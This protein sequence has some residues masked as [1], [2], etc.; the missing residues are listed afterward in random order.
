[1]LISNFPSSGS[2]KDLPFDQNIIF[3]GSASYKDDGDGNWRVKFLT[4]GILTVAKDV[5]IDIFAVGGGGNGGDFATTIKIGSSSVYH[6]GG[7]GGGGYTTTVKNIT[8]KKGKEYTVTVGA[9]CSASG[10]AAPDGVILCEAAGGQ[11]ASNANG[12]SGGSG[13]GTGVVHTT[14]ASAPGSDGSSGVDLKVTTGGSSAT[15]TGGTGQQTTTREFGEPDGDLY[16][17]GGGGGGS[18]YN[19]ALYSGMVG[20]A[21]GG[22][23]GA[24]SSRSTEKLPSLPGG[25]NTGGGG[26]GGAYCKGTANNSSPGGTGIVIIR[27]AR[28][29]TS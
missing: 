20:G 13:G 16:A 29:A 23:R 7:G 9:A 27:N 25:E 21:G 17:G 2:P 10:L 28:I 1:M 8:L 24:Y 4:S 26:G 22:G 12:G 3:T 5:D 19:S 15:F 14:Y 18:D 6:G 11:S